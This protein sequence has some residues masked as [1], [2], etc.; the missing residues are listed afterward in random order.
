M[1][2]KPNFPIRSVCVYCGSSPGSDPDF[3]RAATTLGGSLAENGLRLVYGGGDNGLMGAIAESVLAHKGDVLGVI[4][5]F[6]LKSEQGRQAKNIAGVSMRV[7]P[8]MHTRKRIMFEEADAFVAMPGGIGT[9]EELVE[10]LTWAQLGRHSK[11]VGL[12]NING[13]WSPYV[14]LIRHM[15]DASFLHNP[16]KAIPLVFTSANEVVSGLAQAANSTG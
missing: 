13:F 16:T 8:D 9:L 4:P 5:E 14:E 15:A 1:M 11:P 6:L 12:L 3:K 10:V 7:V 2:D